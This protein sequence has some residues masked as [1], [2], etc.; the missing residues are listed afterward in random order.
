[1]CLIVNEKQGKSTVQLFCVLFV[2]EK[3]GMLMLV[4]EKQ[5]RQFDTFFSGR[6]SLTSIYLSYLSVYLIYLF[7]SISIFY[8]Y[9]S[10]YFQSASPAV[11]LSAAAGRTSL[12]S[13]SLRKGDK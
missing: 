8:L 11:N 4:N 9:L 7:L 1:M 12:T 10:I 5:G 6:T 2:N 13:F 3:Q